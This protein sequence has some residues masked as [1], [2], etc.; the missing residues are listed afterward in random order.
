[1]GFHNFARFADEGCSFV[2][3]KIRQTEST[4]ET[5]EAQIQMVQAPTVVHGKSSRGNGSTGEFDHVRG[6]IDS[7]Q[8]Q[9][10]PLRHEEAGDI[11]WAAGGIQ[12]ARAA[13][14][15]QLTKFAVSMSVR[16]QLHVF[17]AIR[18]R[19]FVKNTG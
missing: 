7:E 16:G 13:G 15:K 9:I 12:Y 8:V 3:R 4:Y 2:T 18:I 17:V 6:K 14:R 5:V 19:E 1:M 10:W 11:A